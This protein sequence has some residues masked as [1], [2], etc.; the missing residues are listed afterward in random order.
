MKM[1]KRIFAAACALSL[2]CSMAACGSSSSDSS[3]SKK[4]AKAM[5]DDQKEQV[6]ALQDKLPDIELSNKTI[7]WMAHYD[8]NPSD[9]KSESPAISLFQTKYGGKI[10]YVQTTWDNRY[11]DLAKAVMANDSP[12]F[13]PA[14]D[15]DAFP[16]G[17][18]KAMFE[19]IDDVVDFSSDIWSSSQ[20]LN[21][22]FVFNGKHYV[23]AI[24]VRP[25]YVCVYN[26]KTISDFGYDDPAE[27][28][29]NDEWT[30]SKFTE[31][32]L[33]F[34]DS[35]ADRYALDGYWY[36]KALND[37][38]GYP[39]IGLEDGKLVNNMGKAEVG[40]VQDLMYNL[41]KNNVVFDRSSNNWNT[42]GDG[43]NGEG[44]GSQLTLFI[45]I[46]TWALED[47]PEKTKTFGSV[48]DGEVMF[49]PMPRMDD[50]DK[51][52]VSTGVNGYLLCKNAPNPDGFN[53]YVNC[54]KVA[55]SEVQNITEEQL[56]TFR[57][58]VCNRL[59]RNTSGMVCAGKSLAGLQFL[60][61]IFHHRTLHKYYICLT[62]GKIEKPDHIRGYLHKDKK[63]NKVIVSRQEF[64]DSLPIE[65][66]YRPLGSN[67]KITLLEVELITGRTHQIRAHLAGTGHPLL[68]DTKYGDSEFNKQYI[69]HGVRHQLLHAYRLVI[70]ETDQ[71]FVAPAPELFCKIIKEENLEEA[72]HE[73][74]ERNMGLRKNDHHSSSD[75]NACE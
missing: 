48:K 19:P 51:Y 30:W 61:R 57:P 69:R 32:C 10:E 11:T 5:T 52:Y 66:K 13:F 27:L 64:K 4:E 55:N 17:A 34:A 6:N 53:A 71:T 67:G 36:G 62:K 70:P 46:G 23:A 42:R 24:D 39:L 12:D 33:D 21:D 25:Q 59:D 75:R 38:C 72:Y 16:K 22:S 35:E 9:G 43:A 63:T 45:P 28:Y 65:T 68:G 58:S 18:I 7:K 50:S 49:V 14:D 74:L 56:K 1:A 40:T 15:M 20:T 47:T 3:S 73:N 37:T 2:A 41:E 54:C 29:A 60:S 8:I 31:M 44:L 26:T